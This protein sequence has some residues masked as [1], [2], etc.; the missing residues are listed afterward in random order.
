MAEQSVLKLD[1]LN[2]FGANFVQKSSNRFVRRALL[3]LEA[4]DQPLVIYPVGK[5]IGIRNVVTNKMNYIMQPNHIKEV[6]G[7]TLSTNRRYLAVHE[8]R[9]N[10]LHCYVSFYDLKVPANPKFMKSVNISELVYG[11]LKQRGGGDE[12]SPAG[13]LESNCKHIISLAFSKDNKHLAA[14]V[15]DKNKDT[16]AVIYDWF[17]KHKVLATYDFNGFDV[18]RISFN[19]KD[20]Q[21]ICTS[22]TNHWRVWKM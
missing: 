9:H 17:S 11:S 2:S 4:F 14:V 10:D 21:Q 22:G 1:Y 19:P 12:L 3:F 8:Q 6:M 15:S 16:R 5:H 20:C 18:Q 13:T 7:L